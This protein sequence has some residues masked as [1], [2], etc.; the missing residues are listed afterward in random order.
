MGGILGGNF[1]LTTILLLTAAFV[2]AV[3][4]HE[5]NHAFVATALGDNTPRQY[6]RLT[7]NPMRHIDPL[8]IL[9]FIM[10]G[11][12]WGWTPVNPS[13]LRP[14]PRLGSALV[15][16]AGP[17]SN[18]LLAFAFAAPL[19]ADLD[20][21]LILRQ[22]LF[23]ATA[24]NLLLFVFNLLPIPPLD[25]FSFLVGVLPRQPSEAL[26]QLERIGPGLILVL[27]FASSFLHL[28]IIGRI[29]GPVA[30]AFGLAGLR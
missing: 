26:R 11:I 28:D 10:V 20:L 2:V 14:N 22:F 1:D 15:A 18:L 25:G 13:N 16:A 27:F 12:G 29:F 21:P 30:R 8:G 5:A 3:A 6:G 17:V 9:M 7:L 19:R 23:L 4:F 24:L